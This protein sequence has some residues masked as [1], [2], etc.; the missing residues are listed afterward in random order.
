MRDETTRKVIEDE[1]FML[2]GSPP[3]TMYSILQNSNKWRFTD[4]QWDEKMEEAK[5]HID[6]CFKL[7]ELQRRAGRF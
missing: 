7:F 5:V 6:F 4:A 2:V 1:P 3:C